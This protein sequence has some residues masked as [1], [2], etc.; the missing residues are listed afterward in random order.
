MLGQNLNVTTYSEILQSVSG[1]IVDNGSGNLPSAPSTVEIIPMFPSK[2]PS[3]IDMDPSIYKYA[4]E[5]ET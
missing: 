4:D 1:C 2:S 3:P 5:S